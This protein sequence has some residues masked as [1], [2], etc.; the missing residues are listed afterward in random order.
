MC[1]DITYITYVTFSNMVMNRADVPMELTLSA[2]AI[3]HVYQWLLLHR[4]SANRA[5]RL[6][7]T[8]SS[9][10]SSMY[11]EIEWEGRIGISFNLNKE[12]NSTNVFVISVKHWPN[13]N[14]KFS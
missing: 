10:E 9:H 1:K 11:G 3:P 6:P 12:K 5:V 2:A 7:N 13:K 8:S 4:R 14:I